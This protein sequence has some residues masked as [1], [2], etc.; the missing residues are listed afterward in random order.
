MNYLKQKTDHILHVDSNRL[1]IDDQFSTFS[2][3]L[4]LEST[5]SGVILEHV[6]LEKKLL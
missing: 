3:N 1:A 4:A 2:F 5:M 6:D